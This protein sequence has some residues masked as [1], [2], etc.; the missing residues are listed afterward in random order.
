MSEVCFITGANGFV[1]RAL[2]RRLIADGHRVRGLDLQFSSD[3]ASD[4]E[5]LEGDIGNAELL[6]RGCEGARWAFHL[7]A[8]LPQ[9]KRPAEEMLRVNV[10]GTRSILR[11]AQTAGVRRFVF[12][13][14][15]EVYGVPPHAPC[16]EGV[17][18]RP[19][20]EYGRNKVEAER[21]VQEAGQGGLETCILRPPTIVGPGM[22]EKMLGAVLDALRRGR[23]VLVPSG[24]TR[25]QL[26]AIS[27]L[28]EACL[29]AAVRPDAAGQ[30]FNL[31]SDGALPFLET[32]RR[33]RGRLASRSVLAPVPEALARLYFRTLL[34]LGIS[35]LEPEHVAIA[36]SDYVFDTGRAK[37]GLGWEPK[38]DNVEALIA[39]CH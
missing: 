9:R 2:C 7:A 16:P 24:R 10:E 4:L 15:C 12:L 39:A 30:V 38:L 13:S 34:A 28:I 14:S 6:A 21:L 19:I 11:A 26:L 35:P 1:G 8:V 23:P 32:A 29:L 20:G 17:P 5:R 18:L 33:V 36:F 3:A 31:G 25:F 27:D 37:C 22:P